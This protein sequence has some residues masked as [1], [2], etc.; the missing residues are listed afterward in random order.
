MRIA[1]IPARGGSKRIP[2]KNIRDF[3]GKPMIGYAIEA[4]AQSGLF[5]HIVVSTDD[6]EIAKL[7]IELKA[8]VP[9]VRPAE[10]SDDHTP[11]VPVVAHAIRECAALG[12]AV[13]YVCCI[14]PAVPFLQPQ[15]LKSAF[16]LFGQSDA[17]F[18]FPV[19]EFPSAIQRAL[20]RAQ[21]G[22]MAPMNPEYELTRTQDLEPAYHDAGQFYWGSARS[23][24]EKQRVHSNAVGHL[25]PSWRVVDIDTLDDWLRAEA[26]HQAALRIK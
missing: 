1:V 11:T 23:W 19:T 9:F 2:R 26:L 16:E 14:Y 17:D 15:D 18:C 5:E 21:D 4:A 3:C 7:A 8:E 22:R 25:M 24:Q 13:N 10:L 12:W 6:Q 20:R